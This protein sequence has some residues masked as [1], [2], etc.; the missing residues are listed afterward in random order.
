[1]HR[2][3]C[4]EHRGSSRAREEGV[5]HLPLG[6]IVQTRPLSSLVPLP[7]VSLQGWALASRTTAAGSVL[8]QEQDDSCRTRF[9]V[10]MSA[11]PPRIQGQAVPLNQ[12]P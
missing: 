10:E 6:A 12:A 3:R 4:A 9:W 7:S 1:M 11:A 8:A 2:S 5:V